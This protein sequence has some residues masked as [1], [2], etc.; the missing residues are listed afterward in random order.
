MGDGAAVWCHRKRLLREL[1]GYLFVSLRYEM[2]ALFRLILTTTL[3]LGF[4]RT[5]QAQIAPSA[6]PDCMIRLL[7]KPLSSDSVRQ[8]LAE[9]GI[10]Y[11]PEAAHMAMISL[12]KEGVLLRT[13][14]HVLTEIQLFNDSIPYRGVTYRRFRGYLPLGM[15]FADSVGVEENLLMRQE[16][17]EYDQ[18][19]DGLNYADILTISNGVGYHFQQGFLPAQTYYGY[20]RMYPNLRM[21]RTLYYRF[22]YEPK[23]RGHYLDLPLICGSSLGGNF[24]TGLRASRIDSAFF[25]SFYAG[26]RGIANTGA[27]RSALNDGGY[28]GLS[29][30]VPFGSKYAPPL[31]NVIGFDYA[32]Y[33]YRDSTKT[34]RV[35][36]NNNSEPTHNQFSLYYGLAYMPWRTR[37]PGIVPMAQLVGGA[38]FDYSSSVQWY[39]NT[40]N[41]KS[42]SASF[43]YQVG[44]GAGYQFKSGNILQLMVHYRATR[45]TQ[46]LKYWQYQD[47]TGYYGDEAYDGVRLKTVMIEAALR[48]NIQSY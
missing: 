46:F 26:Y 8:A 6:Q 36:S 40:P 29:V 33:N 23:P 7:G 4:F 38:Q 32:G 12:P 1:S 21:H 22:I 27:V 14:G 18:T 31:Y 47:G 28:L 45:Y 24:K 39:N 25:M 16:G 37:R 41:W 19:D 15:T 35:S 20:K 17:V 3:S 5:M 2:K 42:S 30:M 43:Y 11:K 10:V 9:L 48:L 13:N 44:A 34:Y